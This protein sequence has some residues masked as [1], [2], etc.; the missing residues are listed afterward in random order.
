METATIALT[1]L[2][3][4]LW[5]GVINELRTGGLDRMRVKFL[6]AARKQ[7]LDSLYFKAIE[8]HQENFLRM[9]ARIMHRKLVL[10]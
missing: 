1:L 5:S 9:E 8:E 10:C 4:I 3:V 6:K 7:T 2:N